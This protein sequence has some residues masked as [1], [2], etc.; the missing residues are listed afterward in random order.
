M[1][2][3]SITIYHSPDCGTSRTVLGMIRAAGFAPVVVE[4]RKVGWTRELLERLL[5]AMG[6]GPRAILRTKGE[7]AAELG[8]LGEGVSDERLLAA[9]VAHPGL[10]ERPIVVTPRGTRLCR[11]AEVV[12]ELLP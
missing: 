7:L 12:L 3:D 9:M 5:G 10:V 6:T 11:P 1:T 4:Y 2:V 8:L